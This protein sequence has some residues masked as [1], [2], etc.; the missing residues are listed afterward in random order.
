MKH[1]QLATRTLQCL[2]IRWTM[3]I[4]IIIVPVSF[5]IKCQGEGIININ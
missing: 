3:D 4:L 2:D 5:N 1:V